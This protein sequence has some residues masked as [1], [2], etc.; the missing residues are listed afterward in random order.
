MMKPFI[1][2]LWLGLN[3]VCPILTLSGRRLTRLAALQPPGKA[4]PALGAAWMQLA[5]DM[6]VWSCVNLWMISLF[7]TDWWKANLFV[8][9]FMVMGVLGG[10]MFTARSLS[11]II[12]IWHR[13]RVEA[14][15]Q[16]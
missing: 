1:Y 7:Q 8:V 4:N 12:E 14:Q 2:H 15:A 6:G 10:A 13:D 3:F 5:G 16:T 9:F 11:R